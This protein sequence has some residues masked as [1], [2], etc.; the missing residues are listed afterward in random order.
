MNVAYI[1]ALVHLA[2]FYEYIVYSECF[3]NVKYLKILPLQ[4]IS[5]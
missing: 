2:H 5:I 1:L 3:K 4:H